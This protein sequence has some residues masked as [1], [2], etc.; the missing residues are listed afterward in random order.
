MA[1]GAVV[2]GT[3]VG[4]TVVAAAVVSGTVVSAAVMA[5]TVAGASVAAVKSAIKEKGKGS[6]GRERSNWQPVREKLSTAASK[7]HR[8]FFKIV[9]SFQS[10]FS[11]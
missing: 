7:R 8:C 4:G 3:V 10:I 9:P 1:G 2:G 6:E 5:G 11:G